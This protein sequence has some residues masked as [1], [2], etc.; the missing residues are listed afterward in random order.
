MLDRQLLEEQLCELPI[1]EYHYIDVSR[2][3]FSQRI[4]DI[5]R[6]EC[7]MYG[8]SWACPPG[9]GTVEECR[10]RC[11]AYR[12]ALLIATVTEVSDIADIRETLDTRADHEEVTRQ[13]ADL[14]RRQTGDVFV[15]SSEACAE[16]E[17]CAYPDAPCRFPDRMH[18]CI[19]SHG[20]LLT[21]TLEQLGIEFQYGGNIVTWFSLLF[22][23]EE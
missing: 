5:C 6:T 7:P 18:P 4:R 20:I 19:E 2:L 22:F 23:N 14:V 11:L 10:S 17:T 12:N 9:T 3:T 8:K 1:Y 15:L 13:A 16:C 21:D